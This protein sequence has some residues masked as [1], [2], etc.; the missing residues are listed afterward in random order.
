MVGRMKTGQHTCIGWRVL[1]SQPLKCVCRLVTAFFLLGI[2]FF[3]ANAETAPSRSVQSESKGLMGE[4]WGGNSSAPRAGSSVRPTRKPISGSHDQQGTDELRRGKTSGGSAAQTGGSSPPSAPAKAPELPPPSASEAASPEGSGTPSAPAQ[5]AAP[6]V[7]APTAP[8]AASPEG[9]STS[10]GPSLPSARAQEP[11]SAPSALEAAPPDGSGM[12][13]PPSVPAQEAE[14]TP[15][16]ASEVASP[17]GSGTPSAPAQDAAPEANSPSAPQESA[18]P[19][20][21]VVIDKPTQE[22]KVFIDG[23]ERYTWEVSTGLRGY[24]TPSGKYT[25]R[26]MNE[27]WYSKQWDDAPMPHA[28]FF[29]KKGHAVHGTNETKNLGKPASHGC[30]RL[31]PEHARILFALVKEKGLEDTEIVLNGDT[32]KS[33][34][35]VASAGAR[36]PAP[37]G[38][39]RS[40]ATKAAS[41]RPS[42]QEMKRPRQFVRRVDPRDFERSRQFSR[43]DWARV[44][45]YGP[46]GMLPPPG[47]YLP[48][49]SRRFFIPDY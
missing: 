48:P 3:S 18:A 13:S 39:S 22:M 23:V 42:K 17:E 43:R 25:A 6:Q 2:P 20:V 14:P 9:S 41:S 44:Y 35:K 12:S 45:G 47:Y 4:Y 34:A 38:K 16:S 26:S 5:D 40:G 11:E 46:H 49:S 28:I 19:N 8:E 10:T 31:A 1:A 32:P 33:E 7:S 30:V 21:L 24:D 29:T 37:K 27:I 15:P 36:K